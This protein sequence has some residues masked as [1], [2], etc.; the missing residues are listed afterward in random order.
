[1]AI[2][3]DA[4]LMELLEEHGS[5]LI[6]YKF[7]DFPAELGGSRVPARVLQVAIQTMLEELAPNLWED[8]LNRLVDFGHIFSLELEMDTLFAEKLFHGEAVAID[9]AYSVVLAYVRGHIDEQTRDRLLAT[10]VALKLPIFHEMKDSKMCAKAM[11][12]R[13]KFSQGQKVPLP[14]AYGRSRI[15]NDIT[16]EQMD[17]ALHLWRTLCQ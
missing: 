4:E 12:E 5:D 8:S 3:K 7:Q 16:Q 1:M 13:N 6:K 14:V 9:M 10:M 15:F 17:E 11:Y 2:V